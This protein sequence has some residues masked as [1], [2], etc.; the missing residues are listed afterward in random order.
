M[1]KFIKK[2]SAIATSA[3]MV[4]LSMGTAMAANFPSGYSATGTAI[5]YGANAAVSDTTGAQSIIDFI[6]TDGGSVVVEGGED[7]KLEKSSDNFN[8]ND[9]F[10]ATYATLD[11][12]EMDFLDDGT[13]DD[14]DVDTDYDQ[15]ITLSSKTLGL[16]ADS[17]YEDKDPTVGFHWKNG[18]TI[19]SYTID[20]DDDI[21]YADLVETELPL[22]G[23]DYYVLSVTNGTVITVLDTA[24]TETVH[25]GESVTVGNYDVELTFVDASN[26]KFVIN[27][28][29]TD[30]I[31]A[32]E[33][34]EL[35]DG[36]YVVVTEIMYQD[37]AEGTQGVEFSIGSGKIDLLDG[38]EA[39]ANDE[40]IDGLEVTLT[41]GAGATTHLS[42]ITLTWKADDDTFLTEE[43]SLTMPGFSVV[44]LAYGGMDYEG[45][46]E[47]ISV[48][49]GETLTLDMGNYDLPVAWYNGTVAYLGEEDHLLKLAT[50]SYTY[51]ALGYANESTPWWVGSAIIDTTVV[52]A[53]ALNMSEDERFIV[54]AI[55]Q[56][57]SDCETAYYEIKNIDVDGGVSDF[58]VELEDLIG[59]DD[60]EFDSIGDTDDAGDI[61][62]T[63]RGFSAD[64]NSALFTFSSAVATP[65]YS[66]AISEKGMVVGLETTVANYY[67]SGATLTFV[68]A[69]K[70]EDVNEGR[71]FTVT[72]TN[73][74]NDNLHVSTHNLTA[75]DEEDTDDVYIGYVPSD[76]ASMFTWD[77]SA[78]EYEFSIDYYGKE[79]VADVHVIAG[80][81]VSSS[82][83]IGAVLVKD[84]EVSTVSSKNLI[85]VG[86]SCVNSVAASLLGSTS[87]L[88]ESA[89][90]AATGIGSG[91]FL[92]KS[93]NSP[94]ATGKTA[95]LVAGYEAADTSNAVTYLRTQ[96]VDMS[97][98]ETGYKGTSGTSAT[99]FTESA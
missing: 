26:A 25:L 50:G 78:D 90:T 19:L 5:V 11:N 38:E 35:N 14:G 1:K 92:I 83:G 84:S 77:K 46:A 65:T 97:D 44:Q 16:F 39:E 29:T 22:L 41:D 93:Y 40:D 73:N 88:C 6:G 30:L 37:Y 71:Q 23:S 94:Y 9:A 49:S 80:G 59:D 74:S 98:V 34:Y 20:F 63:L 76:L 60:L 32:N 54:T 33:E 91:Q 85:V 61:T 68:E 79:A 99:L 48:E 8:F 87:P 10:N 15:T 31:G 24:E 62:V 57:V 58:V 95:L 89:F 13:Y 75:Y 55:D 96:D 70:D 72:V 45:D 66:Y 42:S 17:D 86:G 56:D 21:P 7:F 64:N 2:V 47:T 82:D 53:T 3:L 52:H 28:E 12:D 69:D 18:E 51:A 43:N 67:G 36:S 4:G 81:D 27:G